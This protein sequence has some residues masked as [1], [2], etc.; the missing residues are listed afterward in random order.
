MGRSKEEWFVTFLKLPNGTPSHDTPRLRG[1]RPFGDVFSRLDPEQF[2]RCF[3]QWTQAVADLM[4]WEV[5]AIDGK[6]ARRSHGN[7][8]GEE[9]IHLVIAWVSAN[10]L[11]L[12]QVKA[13]E[14]SNE[15]T[16]VPRVLELLELKGCIVTID[17]MGCQ[18]EIAQGILDRDRRLRAG[19]EG[20]PGTSV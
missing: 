15:I 6:T 12:G 8:S 20:Q 13:E 19:G 14:K 2:Q 1:G 17:G 16:A 5:L 4:P 10:T 3:M 11:T 18:K 9:A 7:G